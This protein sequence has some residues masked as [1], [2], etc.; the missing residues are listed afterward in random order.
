MSRRNDALDSKVYVGGLPSDATSEELEDV[1]RRYGL[2]RPSSPGFAF[3]EFEDSRDAEEPSEPGRKPDLRSKARVELSNGKRRREAAVE[4]SEADVAEIEAIAEIAEGAATRAL[5]RVLL[6]VGAT[7]A[8]L[9]RRTANRR[10]TRKPRPA[11]AAAL[12]RNVPA[13]RRRL[14]GTMEAAARI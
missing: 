2:G 1:F 13:V 8:R 10:D 11:G 12:L 3:V 9:H 4:D 14:R 5:A 6:G 7:L